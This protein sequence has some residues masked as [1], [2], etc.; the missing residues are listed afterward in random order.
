MAHLTS[1]RLAVGNT[2]SMSILYFVICIVIS[3]H[4]YLMVIVIICYMVSAITKWVI[5]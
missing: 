2:E 1:G 4:T 3:V 5:F